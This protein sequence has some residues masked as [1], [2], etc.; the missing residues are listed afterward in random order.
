MAHSPRIRIVD[1]A[2]EAG[3]AR[4]TAALALQASPRLRPETI[5]AVRRAADRLGYVYDRGAARLRSGRSRTVGLIVCEITNAFYAELT[6]G[7]QATLEQAGFVALLANTEESL[8]RQRLMLERFREYHADG[9]LMVPAS[10]TPAALL[11]EI[12]RWGLPCV[13]MVRGFRRGPHAGTDNAGG[14]ALATR[15]LIGLGHRRIAFLGGATPS[16]TSEGRRAGYLKAM[17]EAGLAPELLPCPTEIGDAAEVVAALPRRG[18]TGFVCFNDAVAFGATLGLARRGQM[19][20]QDAAVTGFDD[21][22]AAARWH[23]ALTTVRAS[24]AEIGAA[25]ARLL[26]ERIADPSLPARRVTIAPELI[27]RSSCG[28]Q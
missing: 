1:V 27:I 16:S 21:I 8:D 17:D 12:E 9:V 24:A 11:A 19:A 22:R 7:V 3:V 6:A 25:A 14:V 15:H 10:G 5:T 20:G 4:S 26:L 23:P 28:A 13:T 18:P 2:Q